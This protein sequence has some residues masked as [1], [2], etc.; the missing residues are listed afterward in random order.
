MPKISVHGGPS[1]A[2][3]GA[4][5]PEPTHV[6]G[7]P[8][9]PSSTAV[10]ESVDNSREALVSAIEEKDAEESVASAVEPPNYARMLK[11]DLVDLCVARRLPSEGTADEL[12][13]RLTEADAA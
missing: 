13:A 8:V 1:D 9:E 12:R 10:D 4:G 6:D 3:T 11:A 7:Q 2:I 5:M